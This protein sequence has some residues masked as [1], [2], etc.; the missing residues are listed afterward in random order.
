MPLFVFYICREKSML[1]YEEDVSL[2][3]KTL[4]YE[5]AIAGS[6]PARSLFFLPKI[7]GVKLSE[8]F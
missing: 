3:G 5:A 2:T 8:T 4:L 6:I 1:Y 7:P